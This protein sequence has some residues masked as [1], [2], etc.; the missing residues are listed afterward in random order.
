MRIVDKYLLREFAWPLL[1][2]FDAFAM[3]MI[4]IDLFST[5]D[6]FKNVSGG[7][8]GSAAI[9]CPLDGYITVEPK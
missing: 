7:I 9:Y 3:L 4:V 1:Y 6:E 5:L 8:E 2:C